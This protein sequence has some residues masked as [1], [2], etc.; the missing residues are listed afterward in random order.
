MADA[1][2]KTVNTKINYNNVPPSVF[3]SFGF[4]GAEDLGNMFQFKA[5]FEKEYC[6]ARDI[7]QTTR[8]KS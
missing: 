1:F 5:E 3:R 6:G 4:P 7:D 2:S 8:I